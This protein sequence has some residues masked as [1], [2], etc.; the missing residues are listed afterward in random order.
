MRKKLLLSLSVVFLTAVLLAAYALSGCRSAEQSSAAE[1]MDVEDTAKEP[2]GETTAQKPPVQETIEEGTTSETAT[3]TSSSAISDAFIY[4]LLKGVDW[5]KGILKIEQLEGG[6]NEP[7]VG[8]EIALADQYSAIRSVLIRKTDTEVEYN[9]SMKLGQIPK[10]SEVGIIIKN[11]KAEKIISQ[12][13]ID[14]QMQSPRLET[15]SG[16][17]FIYAILKGVDYNNNIITIEQ[18]LSGASDIQVG[19]TLALE[20]GYSVQLSIVE[21]TQAAENEYIKDI[22][23][24]DIGIN[25]EIG[26][27]LTPEKKVRA[28]VFSLNVEE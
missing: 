20:K 10:G 25:E 5:D 28:I 17:S 9:Q 16:E 13:Y 15:A 1:K 24:S 22:K 12:V 18:L 26:I 23:L 14:E 3:E 4:A 6:P 27:I 21:R 7:Q 8:P 19:D 2:S 11:S